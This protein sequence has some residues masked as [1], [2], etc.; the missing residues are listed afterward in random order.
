MPASRHQDH[1]TSPSASAPFVKGASASTASRPASV[2]IASAPRVGRD[3]MN[4]RSDLGLRK[5]RIFFMTG[6]DSHGIKMKAKANFCSRSFRCAR[7]RKEDDN[8]R[9]PEPAVRGRLRDKSGTD[10][11]RRRDCNADRLAIGT[12]APCRK[13]LFP[14]EARSAPSRRTARIADGNVSLTFVG[15]SKKIPAPSVEW[16]KTW[17]ATF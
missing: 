6:L 11:R 17:R 13:G 9:N 14:C 8:Q 2:T 7:F 16:E 3:G 1:T 4:Y 15:A 10:A 5:I 12:D